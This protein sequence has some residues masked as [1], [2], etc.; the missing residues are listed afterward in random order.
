MSNTDKLK[1]EEVVEETTAEEVEEVVEETTPEETTEE[2]V[3]E[4]T[5]EDVVEEEATEE[6]EKSENTSMLTLQKVEQVGVSLQ[7]MSDTLDRLAERVEKLEAQ[8]AQTKT[9]KVYEV[10]K[11]EVIDDSTPKDMQIKQDRLSELMKLRNTNLAE[12]QKYQDEAW[13]LFTELQRLQ[14]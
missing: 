1:K 3:E 7:K 2:V 9:K 5:T 11:S 8:P 6:V 10:E 14:K 4:T 13:S 12:F